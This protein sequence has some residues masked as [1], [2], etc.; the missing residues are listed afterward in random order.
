MTYSNPSF[1]LF[2]V[3]KVSPWSRFNPSHGNFWRSTDGPKGE[4]DGARD[5]KCPHLALVRLG[6]CGVCLCCWL[7]FV[8]LFLFCE[9]IF[10][11]SLKQGRMMYIVFCFVRPVSSDDYNDVVSFLCSKC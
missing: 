2:G 11:G 7:L 3:G 5:G 8:C 10:S 6:G 1:S 9:A 4:P